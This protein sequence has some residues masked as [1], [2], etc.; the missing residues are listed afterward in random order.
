[1]ACTIFKDLITQVA[2]EEE[3]NLDRFIRKVKNPK[4]G[5]LDWAFID[6]RQPS[7]VF[8]YFGPH[9][10]SAS[11]ILKELHAVEYFKNR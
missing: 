4:T 7:K 8:K 11:Q 2:L 3:H 1:M 9:K 5:E 10:P 6:I